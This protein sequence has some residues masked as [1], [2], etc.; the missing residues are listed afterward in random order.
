MKTITVNASKSYDI[1]I[2]ADVLEQA[3]FLIRKTAGGQSAAVIADD[4][5]ANLY[6]K[7]LADALAENGYRAA[8]YVFPHGET[9]KN[10]GTFLSVLNF[11]AEEKFSRTDVVVALGGGVAGDLAGFAASC[12]MRG[13]NF[14]QMPT[15]L[16]AMVD[17]SVGGKT[18]INLAAG[19]NLA[20]AFYQPALV[21]GDVSLLSTLS[22]ETFRDGCAE[23]IKYGVLADRLLFESLETPVGAQ[24]E[25]VISRCIEI[26]RD[27]VAEDEFEKS[28]R[29]LLNFGHTIGHAIELLGE[30][31]ISHGHAV[32]AGM[33]VVTRA[34]VRMGMCEERCLQDIV[35]ML[36]RYGL[37]ENTRCGAHQL[38]EACLSDKKRDGKS[39]TM[40][41]PAEIGKCVLKEIPVGEIETVIRLGLEELHCEH[42]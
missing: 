40:I 18:A 30:Y 9:S 38:A 1:I 28:S 6:G 19:K 33:A 17:S 16:L 3:G 2:G 15:T 24:S 4:N 41:F 37:P 35:R 25:N 8:Q 27:I 42:E 39:I 20:G 5:V 7:K 34:A 10:A 13:I 14:V 36:R 32:A 12:Y 26:K 11:L 23:I 21:L 29:K 22:P 31:R